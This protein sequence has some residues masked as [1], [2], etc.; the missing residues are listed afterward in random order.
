MLCSKIEHPSCDVSYLA[1]GI[2]GLAIRSIWIG[3]GSLSPPSPMVINP[4]GAVRDFTEHVLSGDRKNMCTEREA[5][6]IGDWTKNDDYKKI[7]ME[8]VKARIDLPWPYNYKV[9]D[10]LSVCPIGLAVELF[11]KVKGLAECAAS[12]EGSAALHKLGK[13]LVEKAEKERTKMEE[14]EAKKRHEAIMTM[15][16]GLWANDL[17]Y[18][19]PGGL[20]QAGWG[21]WQ[22]PYQMVGPPGVSA[23]ANV[24][25][26]GNPPTGW[27]PYVL[28]P[29]PLYRG[30]V[31][32][33][34]KI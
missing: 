3:F 28:A 21:G 25:W 1:P 32:G 30:P 23:Q 22:Y 34:P 6:I 14:E 8:V 20:A 24:E 2:A 31:I 19:A 17:P 4:E 10:L 29:V 18:R 9:L 5:A 15:W 12:V 26:K 33:W 13:P 7:I 11:D 27:N 16:G